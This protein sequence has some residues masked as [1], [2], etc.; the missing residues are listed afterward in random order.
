RYRGTRAAGR[1]RRRGPHDRERP[2]RGGR[3]GP[4]PSAAGLQAARRRFVEEPAGVQGVKMALLAVVL[5]AA[6]S[7][8]GGSSDGGGALQD[9]SQSDAGSSPA[10]SPAVQ[11]PVAGG[12]AACTS[13][14][15]TADNVAG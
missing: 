10:G 6:L 9:G 11:G 15:P 12:A 5:T 8:C 7:G 4:H 3:A 2:P 14:P 13:Q 1:R